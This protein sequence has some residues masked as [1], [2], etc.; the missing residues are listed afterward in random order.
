MKAQVS[1][2]F[3]YKSHFVNVRDSKIHFI[4]EKACSECETVFLFLHGNP[5]SSYLWRNIIPHLT[6][7]GRC[8][9]PDLI[10]FGKSGKP[11]IEYTFWDHYEHVKEFIELLE[12][13]NIILVLHDWGGAIGFHYARLHPEKINAIVFMETFYKPME[14]DSL[15]PF[16]RWLFRKF[17]NE[18]AGYFLNGRLNLFLRFILPLSMNRRLT[19]GEKRTYMEPFTTV[20]SRKPIIK[21]P[22]EL[23]FR[24]SGT[25][26][27][28]I[29]DEYYSWLKQTKLPK[30]VLYANPGVQIKEA[31][32]QELK[33]SLSNLSV[34]Y[35]G[36]GKHFIQEDEPNKIGLAVQNWFKE[37][38]N[39]SVYII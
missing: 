21:F 33:E 25:K 39:K 20:E 24:G 14:W 15:D 10:G 36:R 18:K 26:N 11:D 23:P 6:S 30:L 22:Q 27:E 3:P 4:D 31:N 32:V 17:Q 16:A 34:Q 19:K 13:D 7:I 1:S 2:K 28:K 8:V 29:A 5:T 12:L 38:Q 35:I 9:A 37:I